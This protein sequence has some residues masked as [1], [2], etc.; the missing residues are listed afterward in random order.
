MCNAWN[1]PPDCTCGWGGDGHLGR[2][3]GGFGAGAGG[4]GVLPGAASAYRIRYQTYTVPNA[5]CP[6]CGA[7]VFF[8]QSPSGGRVFFD[9]LGPPW[10]KH[11]CTSSDSSVADRAATFL[12]SG[13]VAMPAI[14]RYRWEDDKWLPL[15]E[16]KLIRAIEPQD[17]YVLEGLLEAGFVTIYIR[18]HGIPI[19]MEFFVRKR[20]WWSYEV[21]GF[22]VGKDGAVLTRAYLGYATRRGAEVAPVL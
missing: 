3:P 17:C 13:P 16:A 19:N 11:P 21:M 18:A 8:Y 6:V 5:S 4:S 22:Y 7:S 1:H 9:E 15:M 10:P 20:D 14:R 2:S 12:A